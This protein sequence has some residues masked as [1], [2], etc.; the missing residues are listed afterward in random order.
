MF[1][2]QHY[3]AIAKIIRMVTDTTGKIERGA[4]VGELSDYF[5]R[6]NPNFDRNLFF[7]ACYRKEGED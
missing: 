4:L 1:S 5:E 3:E 6:D 2:K 7:K